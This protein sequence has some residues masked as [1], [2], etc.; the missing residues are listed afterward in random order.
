[1]KRI[2]IK[3]LAAVLAV[4]TAGGVYTLT[5]SAG[6][7]E[8]LRAASPT[9]SGESDQIAAP[10]QT[11]EPVPEESMPISAQVGRNSNKT[12]IV[13]REAY[14]RT[15]EASKP[16]TAAYQ[17]A[18]GL[19]YEHQYEAAFNKAA[20]A[21]E[22]GKH[23]INPTRVA[24]AQRLQGRIRLEQGRYTE[25]LILLKAE[26]KLDREGILDLDIALCYVKL[27]DLA[28]ARQFYSDNAIVGKYLLTE[29][30]L[31][32]TDTAANFEASI[33]FA[34]GMD[35]YG[36]SLYL[37]ALDEF[38]LAEAL[39]PEIGAIP[40]YSGRTLIYL[41]RYLDS[42]PFFEKALQNTDGRILDDAKRRYQ[43]MP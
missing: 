17:S 22:L 36:R 8:D 4:L 43:R 14:E 31:P 15:I 26:D 16:S 39:A 5:S 19:F 25:A 20:E 40:Y 1:M 12:Y 29:S 18:R 35:Y 37:P 21:I 33:R 23:G 24:D 10:E 34:R 42:K 30:D 3:S 2:N 32:G 7:Q 9:E 11:I 41:N 27:G 28:M 38:A 6:D 13:D